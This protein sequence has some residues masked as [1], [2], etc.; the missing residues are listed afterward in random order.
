VTENVILGA[1]PLRRGLI[2]PK[3]VAAKVSELSS[4]YGLNL[5]PGRRN[6]DW[7]CTS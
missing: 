4:Q 6:E 2:D 3:G 5:D 7:H 1:E